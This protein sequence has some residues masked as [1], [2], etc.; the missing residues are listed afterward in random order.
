MEQKNIPHKKVKV[1]F[2]RSPLSLKVALTVL[3]LFSMAALTALRWVHLEFQSQAS[4]LREKAA[5]LE[6]ENS[7]IEE[8][9][10]NISSVQSIEAI[11]REEL[12]LVNPDTVLIDPEK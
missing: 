5:Q 7:V 1:E 6:Y 3:I 12:G 9:K 8:R 11:A 4:E 10:N 2:R